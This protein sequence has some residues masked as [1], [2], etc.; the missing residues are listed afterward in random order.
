MYIRVQGK[1]KFFR[2]IPQMARREWEVVDDDDRA[3][4]AVAVPA[5]L[6][7]VAAAAIRT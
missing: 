7:G 2:G 3:H 5:D 6:S 1:V 4:R